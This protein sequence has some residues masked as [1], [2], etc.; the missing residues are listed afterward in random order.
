MWSNCI[1]SHYVENN[2]YVFASLQLLKHVFLYQID[3]LCICN[4]LLNT[5]HYIFYVYY[6]FIV[7]LGINIEGCYLTVLWYNKN[8]VWNGNGLW[9]IGVLF[10]E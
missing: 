2:K 9:D 4:H 7:L 1:S 5:L 3:S 6:K 8:C 10:N